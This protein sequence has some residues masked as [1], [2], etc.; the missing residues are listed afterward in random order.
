MAPATLGTVMVTTG[1]FAENCWLLWDEESREAVVVDPGEGS[2]EILAAIASRHLVVADIWLTHAHIDHVLGV[3][4][5][6]EATGA[7]VWLHPGD[8][9]WYDMLPEQGRFFGM[10]GLAPLAPPD[11]ELAEGDVVT[12]GPH[13]FTVR[14]VPGHAPGHVAFLGDGLVVSGDVLFLDSIGRTDLAGGDHPALLRSI[15]DVLLPLPD[16]TRVLPGHGP[17]T[18]I[19]RERRLNPFIQQR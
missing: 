8:R 13:R 19:G 9:R 15:T 18:T 12:V 1:G 5:L 2:E 6:R 7:P 16:A 17:E 10:T 4:A 3:T 14:H 11:C